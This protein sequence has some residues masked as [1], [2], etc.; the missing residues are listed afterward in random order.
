MPRKSSTRPGSVDDLLAKL[1]S[2]SDPVLNDAGFQ[3]LAARAQKKIKD[4]RL[5][6]RFLG[7]AL[8]VAKIGVKVLVK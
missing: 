4:R 3:K 7:V 8:A 1:G 2:P 6:K 5:L